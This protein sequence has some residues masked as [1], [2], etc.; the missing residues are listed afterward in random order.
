VA[1]AGIGGGVNSAR[2]GCWAASGGGGGRSGTVVA[3]R[4]GRRCWGAGELELL[5][6]LLWRTPALA[7]A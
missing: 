5:E 6:L 4:S 7:A 3:N 2:G 1:H